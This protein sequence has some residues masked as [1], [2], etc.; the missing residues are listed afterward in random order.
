MTTIMTWGNNDGIQ[1]RC[2]AKC[3]NAIN[4]H[5]DCMCGGRFHGKHEGVY[6]DNA[7]EAYKLEVIE[8]ATAKAATLGLKLEICDKL[9]QLSLF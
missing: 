7:I 5:C 9:R 8:Q 6:L 3:H 1:G 4:P 2:D